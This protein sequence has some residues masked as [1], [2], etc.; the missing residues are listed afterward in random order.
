MEENKTD[1]ELIAK[2]LAEKIEFNDFNRAEYLMCKVPKGFRDNW[3][4]GGS[5]RFHESWDWLMPVVEK[6][7]EL[8]KVTGYPDHQDLFHFR[9]VPVAKN[10]KLVYAGCVIFIKWYNLTSHHTG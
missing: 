6:I 8:C 7:N 1:N 4:E 10:I 2:F 9:I 5:L 3:Y